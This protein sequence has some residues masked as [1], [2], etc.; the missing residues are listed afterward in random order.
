MAR[1]TFVMRDG[2][3]VPKHLAQP[4]QTRGPRSGLPRPYVISDGIEMR[5]P[6]TGEVYT[7]KAKFREETRARG[8]TEVGNEAFPEKKV[9]DPVNVEKDVKDAYDFLEQGGSVG[10]ALSTCPV[11]GS[12]PVR[13]YDAP[14]SE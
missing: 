6:V 4:L 13:V 9:D 5:H 12:T 7:S 11:E 1:G 10:E 2:K 14:L 3:L 8:L